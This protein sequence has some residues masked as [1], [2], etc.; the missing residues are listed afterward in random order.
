M[1]LHPEFRPSPYAPLIPEQHWFPADEEARSMAYEKL[2]SSK[3]HPVRLGLS[4]LPQGS[5]LSRFSAPNSKI[6]P[7]SRS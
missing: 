7:C 4:A 1:S 2:L 6:Q 3:H 5:C